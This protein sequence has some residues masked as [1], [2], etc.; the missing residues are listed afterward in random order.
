MTDVDRHDHF[1]ALFNKAYLR[2]FHLGEQGALVEIESIDRDVEMTLPGGA[3]TKS[4]VL[5][6]KVVNGHIDQPLRPL[7]LNKTNATSIAAIHGAATSG[8]VGKEIVLF[9]TETKLKGDM[10]GCIRVR[11]RKP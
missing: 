6:Y 7:V 11:G 5:R 4:P 2:W 10:V 3:K 1:E 9:P 8:W